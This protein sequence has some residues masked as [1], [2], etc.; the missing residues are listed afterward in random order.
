[1]HMGIRSTALRSERRSQGKRRG[2]QQTAQ[3]PPSPFEKTA[4]ET[5]PALCLLG[6]DSPYPARGRG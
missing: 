5:M 4:S 1:M 2:G 3:P 6:G